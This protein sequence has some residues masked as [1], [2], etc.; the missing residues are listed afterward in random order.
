V[1]YYSV[2]EMDISDRSWVQ[3]YVK[4]VTRMVEQHGG[5]YLARRSKVER[6]EGSERSRKCF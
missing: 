4:N 6:V 5:R 1:K 2:V 3:E